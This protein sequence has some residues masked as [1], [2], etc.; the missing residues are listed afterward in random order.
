MDFVLDS[1]YLED[2]MKKRDNDC[3]QD[4][5]IVGGCEG[6][7]PVVNLAFRHPNLII[8]TL[9]L[10]LL[11]YLHSLPDWI[12]LVSEG[13]RLRSFVQLL[14]LVRRYPVVVQEEG[15]G[16]GVQHEV[17]RLVLEQETLPRVLAVEGIVHYVVYVYER[18]E[19][20]PEVLFGPQVCVLVFSRK[21][22]S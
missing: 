9:R 12:A 13:E 20:R 17:V 10:H 1:Q 4:N 19:V 16:V 22:T 2:E 8:P 15:R 21:F 14:Q 5:I 18:L 6:D 11:S 3:G 7:L